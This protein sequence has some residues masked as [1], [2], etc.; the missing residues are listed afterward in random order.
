MAVEFIGLDASLRQALSKVEAG[1]KACKDALKDV[2]LAYE[3]DVKAGAPVDTGHYRADTI[4]VKQD[5]DG[6]IVGTWGPQGARLEF[7]FNGADSRGRVYHQREQ[8]HWRPPLEDNLD[9]YR[10]II[11]RIVNEAIKNG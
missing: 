11:V 10:D 5:G 9:R 8:P 6:Y 1:S 4:Y 2:A 3:A 7:G